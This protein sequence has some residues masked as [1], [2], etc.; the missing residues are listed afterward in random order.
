MTSCVPR[1][2]GG[3]ADESSGAAK[4]TEKQAGFRS[5]AEDYGGAGAI[6]CH[7]IGPPR[8]TRFSAG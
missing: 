5:A 7:V 6:S 8:H 4:L 2:T 1:A 3:R